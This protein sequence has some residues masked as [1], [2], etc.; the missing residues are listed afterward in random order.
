[1]GASRSTA[2]SRLQ[3]QLQAVD[4]LFEVRDARLPVSSAHPK[5]AEIFGNK[6]RVIVLAKQD[7]AD[8]DLLK[9]WLEKLSGGNGHPATA[10]SFKLRK[11]QDKLIKLAL[12]LTEQKRG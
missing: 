2:F 7:L 5:T 6:P 8:A 3:T 4:L 1:M 11:G 12:E 9:S 10:L